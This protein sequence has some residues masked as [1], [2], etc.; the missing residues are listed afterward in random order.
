MCLTVDER[1]L[2]EQIQALKKE[3]NDVMDKMCE[4]QK[5]VRNNVKKINRMELKSIL[6]VV[7]FCLRPSS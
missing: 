3:R 4:L 6:I 7:P 1:K 2:T 5:R